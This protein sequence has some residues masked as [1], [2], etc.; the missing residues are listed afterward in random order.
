MYW[1]GLEYVAPK[2]YATTLKKNINIGLNVNLAFET[3]EFTPND[4]LNYNVI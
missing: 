3:Y 4:M 2:E 1:E